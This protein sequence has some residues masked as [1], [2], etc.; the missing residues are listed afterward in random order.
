MAWEPSGPG[1]SNLKDRDYFQNALATR[2][3][4]V[5]D[6]RAGARSATARS[7]PLVVISAPIMTTDGKVRGV[8]AA[9][10]NLEKFTNFGRDYATINRGRITILDRQNRVVYSNSHSYAF[11]QQLHK[12]VH[13]SA[14]AKDAFF[15]YQKNAGSDRQLVVP[16]QFLRVPG[17]CLCSNPC[18]KSTAKS[19]STI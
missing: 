11:M 4:Y 10:L 1:L 3:A 5:S 14:Q 8:L 19:A 7:M 13:A 9:S 2:Q 6:G 15:Y 17:R 18:L 12:L 16:P